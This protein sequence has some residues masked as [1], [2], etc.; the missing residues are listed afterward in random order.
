MKQAVITAALVVGCIGMSV[1]AS[2][3]LFGGRSREIDDLN[4]RMRAAGLSLTDNTKSLR[5]LDARVTALAA[6]EG[7]DI[8][9]AATVLSRLAGE[10]TF[11]NG[12]WCGSDEQ[13]GECWRS[14]PDCSAFESH[15]NQTCIPRH[16]AFCVPPGNLKEYDVCFRTLAACQEM[17]LSGNQSCKG[18]E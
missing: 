11:D 18:V 10:V 7:S 2:Y 12:W 16:V 15:N 3:F 9:N 4:T 8:S 5:D 6:K 13:T 14:H 17:G 1:S